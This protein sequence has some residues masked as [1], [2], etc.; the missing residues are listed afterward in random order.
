MSVLCVW[1]G[2]TLLL[3]MKTDIVSCRPCPVRVF[4]EMESWNSVPVGEETAS[5]LTGKPSI[6]DTRVPS[7]IPDIVN[8][9]GFRRLGSTKRSYEEKLIVESLS[10]HI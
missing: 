1:S 6:Q 3:P 2:G 8:E 7:L 9:V 10:L 5:S 4:S